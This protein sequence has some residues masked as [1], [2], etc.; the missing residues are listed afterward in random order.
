MEDDPT[1]LDSVSKRSPFFKELV[2][3]IDTNSVAE[4][5]LS[6]MVLVEDSNWVTF[7]ALSKC[8]TI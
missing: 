2:S 4:W 1:T 6:K 8:V 7:P 5:I 3:K